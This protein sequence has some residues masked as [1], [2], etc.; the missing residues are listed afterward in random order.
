MKVV[1]CA[2]LF[3]HGLFV[4]RITMTERPVG[5]LFL[6]GIVDAKLA[7]SRQ[8][9]CLFNLLSSGSPFLHFMGQNSPAFKPKEKNWTGRINTT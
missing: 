1:Q 6:P 9:H 4:Q 8:V 3:H 2:S 5:F 7:E